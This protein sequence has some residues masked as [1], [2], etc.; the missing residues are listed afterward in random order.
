MEGGIAV[1]DHVERRVVRRL[2]LDFKPNGLAI[3]PEGRR[4]AVNYFDL[5]NTN[6]A[7]P[8]VAI[9]ELETGRVLF[10][11]RSQVGKGG[12]AW[13]A[14][15]Q[16]LAVGS[17]GGDV[18]TSG[19]SDA[20]RLLPCFRGIRLRSSTSAS[21]TRV[22]CWRPPAGMARPGSGTASRGSPWRWRRARLRGSFAP[23]DRRLA[24]VVAWEGRRLGRSLGPRV[25][26]APPRHARQPLRDAG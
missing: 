12:L 22:T 14:D 21:R 24:F 17:H 19:T 18:S 20:G 26:D 3:D 13:S 8:R 15:G 4:L 16:L 5:E 1:W 2:P 9:L 11:W 7:E 23:D 10:D 25:P 6:G